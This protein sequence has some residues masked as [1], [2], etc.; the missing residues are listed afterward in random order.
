MIEM[1]VESVTGVLA[2]QSDSLYVFDQWCIAW[3]QSRSKC[4]WQFFVNQMAPHEIH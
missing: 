2:I 1:T 3:R 4:L